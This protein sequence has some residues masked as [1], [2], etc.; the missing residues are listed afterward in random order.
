MSSE[1][2]N[3]PMP[4]TRVELCVFS[5]K[6]GV[7]S[8]L[9]GQREERPHKGSWALPGGVLRTLDDTSLDEAAKRVARERLRAP[10]Q[11]LRQQCAVGGPARD[12][13][14]KWTLSV[15]YRSLMQFEHFT[16]EPGKRIDALRWDP[17]SKAAVAKDLAF[18]HA[19]IIANAVADL[20]H[21]VD[22]LDLPYGLL[23]ETFSLSKLQWACE[24][25]LGRALDK[26]SFRRRIAE[27]DLLEPTGDSTQGD[28][29]R[30]AQLY[31]A[32]KW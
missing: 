25:V 13:R 10:V 16:P 1:H 9:L 27:R 23:Q 4:Y 20:R 31:R 26:S 29:F 6:E 30:P 21:E 32:K 17:A 15:V 22:A 5:I 7:L 28:A 18:D 3:Y 24:A 11:Y 8:V 12:E 19:E 2:A 14:A